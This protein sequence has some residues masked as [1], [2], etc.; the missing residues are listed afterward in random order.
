MVTLDLD[1]ENQRMPRF[2]TRQVRQC[3]RRFSAAVEGSY[4]RDLLNHNGI[5]F[6][7]NYPILKISGRPIVF[8]SGGDPL[9]THPGCAGSPI[10]PSR[11]LLVTP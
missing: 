6:V 10:K 1:W 11:S 9:A 5:V 7:L 8:G 3:S 2:F 4:L